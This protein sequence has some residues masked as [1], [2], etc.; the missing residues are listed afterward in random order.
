LAGVVLVLGITPEFLL[1]I[2]AEAASTAY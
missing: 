2:T 1:K